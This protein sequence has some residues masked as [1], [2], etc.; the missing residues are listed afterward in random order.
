[1]LMPAFK[2]S[3]EEVQAVAEYVFD[4]ALGDKW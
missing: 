2:N 1:M 4:T 3:E